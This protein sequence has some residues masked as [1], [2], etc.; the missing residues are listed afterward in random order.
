MRVPA[1]LAFTVLSSSACFVEVGVPRD[2]A[3]V[4]ETDVELDEGSH[5]LD[6]GDYDEGDDGDE[7]DGDGEDESD[8]G[9]WSLDDEL[10]NY[11]ELA[12]IHIGWDCEC[13]SDRGEFRSTDRCFEAAEDDGYFWMDDDA[14]DCMADAARSWGYG[15]GAVSCWSWAL[16]EFIGCN[17]DYGCWDDDDEIEPWDALNPSCVRYSREILYEECKPELSEEFPEFLE[18]VCRGLIAFP[19]ARL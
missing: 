9:D 19:R 4:G 15:A 16:D 17:R 13:R 12:A 8:E 5:E 11:S 1:I 10:D 18:D 2:S 3:D 14:R 7:G 6:E